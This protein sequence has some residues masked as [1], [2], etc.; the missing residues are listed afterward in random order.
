MLEKQLG[1]TFSGS[2][3]SFVTTVFLNE[4]VMAGLNHYKIGPLLN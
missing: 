1:A 3:D 4:L 2:A